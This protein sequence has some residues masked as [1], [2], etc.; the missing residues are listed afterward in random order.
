MKDRDQEFLLVNE[1][2]TWGLRPDVF[3]R[4]PNLFLAA[5]YIRTNT[6]LAT[7][8]AANEAA[9]RAVNS[10]IDAADSS[11]PYC[12]VWKLREPVIFAPWR[13]ED[14]ERYALGLPWNGRSNWE[15][16][17]RYYLVRPVE[18]L[19][20]S[21][22]RGTEREREE[23]GEL[24]HAVERFASSVRLRV[25][26]AG[27]TQAHVSATSQSETTKVTVTVDVQKA[28]ERLN[29]A[30]LG[31]GMGSLAAVCALTDPNNPARDRIGNVTVYQMGWRLGGKGASG[32][33][34]YDRIEEHGL[35]IW[36]GFYENA[37]RMIRDVYQELGR[38]A[39]A[40]LATWD[41]AFKKHRLW[42]VD[43]RVNESW[44]HWPFEFPTDNGTPGTGGEFP[45]IHEYLE[46]LL[47]L[48]REQFHHSPHATVDVHHLTGSTERLLREFI[49][50]AEH[51]TRVQ[52]HRFLHLAHD[53]VNRVHPSQGVEPEQHYYR[54]AN[55]LD[56]FSGWLHERR[57]DDAV[58]E[59]DGVR[60]THLLVDLLAATARGL[61]RDVLLT[62]NH[63]LSK[64][65][66]EDFRAWIKRHGASKDVCESAP[67]QGF[68]YDLAFA[69]ENGDTDR[70]AFAAGTALRCALRVLFTYKGAIFWKMQAGMGDTVF[71]PIYEVLRKR[72][73]KFEFFHTVRNVSLAPD[74]S[75]ISAI[76]IGRQVTLK[77]GS[78]QP[79]RDVD[80]L[81]CW[82]STPDF[83]QIVE[84]AELQEK[85]INLESF[86]TTWEDRESINLE[87]GRDFDIALLGIPVGSLPYICPELIE[88]SSEWRD[89]VQNVETI[90]TQAFQLW[91]KPTL[92]AMGWTDG[93]P[94]LDGYVPPLNT[95][96]DMSQL[97]DREKWPDAESP[98]S[99][100][101]FCGPM[102]GG[103]PDRDDHDAPERE[104]QCVKD[105]TRAML[106]NHIQPLWPCAVHE[107]QETSLDWTLLSDPAGGSGRERLDSQFFRANIDPSERYV[108]SV[109]GSSHYRLSPGKSGF[110]SLV[111]AG[112]WTDNGI[113]AGCIEAAVMSGLLASQ[114]ICG[115]PEDPDIIGLG[116]A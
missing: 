84:G 67:V 81:P 68:L 18:A 23:L 106:E 63:D 80:G 29:I 102:L 62:R 12:Q 57:A 105:A 116:H 60:R 22:S 103:I 28:P 46:L 74:H 87:V 86:W 100:A 53:M 43:E 45:T 17:S 3:T 32:R 4:I 11:E 27:E 72:G 26:G 7:M 20:K 64:L 69:Y 89:M 30:V 47:G 5:D 99:I 113:N 111:L 88:A 93:S 78:Y 6:D 66:G 96:A 76:Q 31:G 83:D 90:R 97:I 112:D 1:I 49:P 115:Y 91:M 16:A 13:A 71:G 19:A 109:P 34:Q 54:V 9:R 25:A 51:A 82:P 108:L 35:H 85:R 24:A 107:N 36:L 58:E 104:T 14:E 40:P 41:Q 50:D 110:R 10:I 98:G 77:D 95:W 73:V 2:N 48:L 8:E 94:V 61:I 55:L 37:F 15:E 79:L 59:H 70:P 65:D 44:K 38:D 21:I 114:A 101:Y 39:N 75:S 56:E 33:G 92:D 42:V 52:A